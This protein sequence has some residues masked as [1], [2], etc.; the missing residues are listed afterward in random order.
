[1]HYRTQKQIIIGFISIIIATFAIFIFLILISQEQKTLPITQE[2]LPQETPKPIFKEIEVISVDLLKIEKYGTYDV[3]AQIKNS[4]LEYGSSNIIYEF[5][6]LGP[7]RLGEA[8]PEEKIIKK[9]AGS[10]FMLANTT[11]YIVKSAIRLPEA[12]VSVE[13]NILS[14]S[15]QRLAS[16]TPSDLMV[17]SL[18]VRRDEDLKTTYISGLVHNRTPYNLKN[19]EVNLGMYTPGENGKIVASGAT[20]LQLVDRGAT[21]SF[22]IIWPGLLPFVE[23]DARVES[24][25]FENSNFIRDYAISP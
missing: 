21:R 5:V 13:L 25:F 23:I 17:N 15:W 24:N 3:L 19:I 1:M 18:S 8:D 16:F 7:P 22:Q 11:R 6:F 2:P 10:T 12:P 20:N 9:I 14:Q 4:N